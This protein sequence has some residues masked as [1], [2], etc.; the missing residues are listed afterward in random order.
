MSP[1]GEAVVGIDVGGERKGFHAIELRNGVFEKMT[2]TSPA[3][4][5]KWC[6]D[7]NAKIVAVDAPCGWSQSGSSR[8]AEQDLKLGN[9]KI[10]C[11]ATPTLTIAQAHKKGFYGWVFNGGRLYKEL[12]PHYPLFDGNGGT[13][14]VCMES[15]PHAVACFL[16]GKIVSREKKVRRQVLTEQGYDESSLPNADF[17]DAAL[18]ALAAR[19]FREGHSQ[20]FGQKGEGFIV[21][22]KIQGG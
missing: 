18:G 15:F 13:G 1:D 19:A 21:V 16:L 7:Q 22:P 8:L 4:I 12:V 5:V 2:S 9:N 20:Y 11:F 17:V 10:H 14:R 6:L 3:E